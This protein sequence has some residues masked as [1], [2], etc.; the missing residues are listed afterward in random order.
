M[1]NVI[2]CVLAM[3]VGTYTFIKHLNAFNSRKTSAVDAWLVAVGVMGWSLVLYGNIN[4]N[5]N[6]EMVGYVMWFIYWVGDNLKIQH[7]CIK[8]RR[9]FKKVKS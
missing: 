1:S 2:I 5:P 4:N 6:G 9:K 3:I 7:H 8:Y